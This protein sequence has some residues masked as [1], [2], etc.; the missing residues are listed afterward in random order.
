MSEQHPRYFGTDGIRGPVGQG[1]MTEPFLRRLGY[2]LGKY[3]RR[4]N[5]GAPVSV[6]IGGDTRESTPRIA[7]WL[8]EGLT[9]QG[10]FAHR[11]GVV[12]TPA[13][14]LA[15]RALKGKLGIAIT[16]SHNPWTDNGVKLFDED[17]LKLDP[18]E[19]VAIEALVDREPEPAG[20]APVCV[21]GLYEYPEGRDNYVNFAR[22]LLDQGALKGWKIVLDTA[23]GATAFTTPPVF[24]HLGAQLTLLGDKPDGKNIN[25]DCG[26]EHP[27]RIVAKVKEIGADIGFAHDGDGDRLVVVDKDGTRVDGDKLLGMLALASF[28]TLPSEKR[29]L[30]TTVQSNLGLDQAVEKAGGKVVRVPVGDRNVL[31]KMR[32]LGATLG[33]ENSGHIILGDINWCG[34]GLLAALRICKILVQ[35][36]RSLTDWANETRLLPQFLCNMKVAKKLPLTQCPALS[37]EIARLEKHLKGQGRVMVRYSGTESKIRLLVEAQSQA[38]VDA[39]IEALKMA[40]EKDLGMA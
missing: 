20:A 17:G 25:L 10:I 12:P 28:A 22:S 33:G 27:E 26:S 37:A 31:H 2:A 38:E 5:S 14:P 36:K 34:D 13:V 23:N 24:A 15:V 30:V 8:A 7:C 40:A 16:A 1:C 39:A 18:A 32:E 35:S 6:L 19:E 29:V 4:K 21:K 3:L 9:A 11:L